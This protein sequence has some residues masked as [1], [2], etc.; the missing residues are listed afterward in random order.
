MSAKDSSSSSPSQ[1]SSTPGTKVQLPTE[2][3]LRNLTKDER[4]QQ[5]SQ[6]FAAASKSQSLVESLRS[7][8]ALLTNPTERNRVLSEAYE[9]EVEARGLTKKAKIL[10][11]GTF[12]G[13]ASG[14][15]IGVASAMGLGTGLGVVLGTVVSVPTGLL[16]T[17]VGAGTG[18]I[19]GPWIKLRGLGGG[20]GKEEEKVVQVPQEAI[21]SGAVEVNEKSG[22]VKVKDP[23]A[24]EKALQWAQGLTQ[25][26]EK[27]KGIDD[28]NKSEGGEK[29]KPKKLEVR[30]NKQG[31]EAKPDTTK[32]QL[33]TEAK[34]KRKP[35]K[36]EVRS[37]KAES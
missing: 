28:P 24:L 32:P 23:G 29:R 22:D 37:K 19:H 17:L 2:N 1:P 3:D 25:E 11:S 4:L 34:A 35:P 27:T 6:A 14:A 36:L 33:T 21:D 9:R 18:A 20:D 26:K 30:S 12:Q 7:K 16:G 15:G 10:E 13:A 31:A 8:A 5:A